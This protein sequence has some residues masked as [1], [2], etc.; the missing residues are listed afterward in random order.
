MFNFYSGCGSGVGR[1]GGEQI[2]TAGGAN[3]GSVRTQ[4]LHY[5]T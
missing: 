3:C 2:L 5:N 1:S 4:L